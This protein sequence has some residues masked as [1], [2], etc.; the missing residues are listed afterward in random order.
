M[1]FHLIGTARSRQVPHADFAAAQ[2]D[3]GFEMK[4]REIALG[5]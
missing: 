4:R 3:N 2:D 1:H 5:N